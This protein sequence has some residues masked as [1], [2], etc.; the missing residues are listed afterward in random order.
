MGFYCA[1]MRLLFRLVLLAALMAAGCAR[2]RARS[3]DGSFT[4]VPANPSKEQQ[5]L[6]VTPGDS[7]VGKVALVNQNGRFVVLNFPLGHLPA[8]EQRLS[9]YRRGIKV[10][11]VKVSGQPLDDNVVADLIAG[12]SEVGDEARKD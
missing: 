11:E 1:A 5:N 2:K 12:D 10:G 6:I 8:T 3:Q 4:S 9:L 7:L